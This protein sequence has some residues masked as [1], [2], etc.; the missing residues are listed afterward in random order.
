MMLHLKKL[1]YNCQYILVNY[2]E[3]SHAVRDPWLRYRT[4]NKYLTTFLNYVMSYH[5]KDFL[6]Q[7]PGTC[8]LNRLKVVSHVL[9]TIVCHCQS[10][11]N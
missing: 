8:I 9:S 3:P 4:M 2:T 10:L 5:S 6:M 1:I 7:A 11:P